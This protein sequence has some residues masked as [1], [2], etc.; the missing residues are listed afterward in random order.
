MVRVLLGV[1]GH[2]WGGARC[3]DPGRSRLST[4]AGGM[5]VTALC[6]GHLQREGEH[7][8]ARAARCPSQGRGRR[9]K[10]PHRTEGRSF[11]CL[12]GWLG[13]RAL[14]VGTSVPAHLVL[15]GSLCRRPVGGQ[16][17]PSLLEGLGGVGHG[18]VW[19]GS[20]RPARRAPFTRP[21][22]GAPVWPTASAFF[23]FRAAFPLTPG[24]GLCPWGGPPAAC[25]QALGTHPLAH[26]PPKKREHCRRVKNKPRKHTVELQTVLLFPRFRDRVLEILL[27]APFPSS[28]L[29]ERC[30]FR[31]RPHPSGS[32]IPTVRF[33]G[34]W[35]VL[36]SGGM[37]TAPGLAPGVPAQ[38]SLLLLPPEALGTWA[39]VVPCRPQESA[40]GTAWWL[41]GGLK[42]AGHLAGAF[43]EPHGARSQGVGGRGVA[44]GVLR[45]RGDF[46]RKDGAGSHQWK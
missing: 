29:K 6:F 2:V 33:R 31:P 25:R 38:V 12:A 5:Q 3:Q 7:A 14:H 44:R 36:V 42:C 21:S 32:L 4:S 34:L 30:H 46:L 20:S 27:T 17:E 22:P 18:R 24:G 1:R 15:V 19:C 28:E 9:Q 45:V 37:V 23:S 39:T 11:L 13:P 41:V 40:Q 10:V 8:P 26:H 35:E 16:G 43:R